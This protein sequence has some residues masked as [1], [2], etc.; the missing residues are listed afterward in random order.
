MFPFIMTASP[1][2]F[3]C[4]IWARERGQLSQRHACPLSCCLPSAVWQLGAHSRRTWWRL[5]ASPQTGLCGEIRATQIKITD[6]ADSINF[7]RLPLKTAGSLWLCVF[8]LHHRLGMRN[9][10]IISPGTWEEC[11]F[12][13]LVIFHA[14]KPFG[15][16][17]T[18][19]PGPL[20]G[21][22]FITPLSFLV[23]T[24]SVPAK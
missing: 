10:S 22:G 23:A 19:L 9:P 7:L 15:G 1:A 18:Q 21:M 17:E 4:L 16:G 3:W 24:V 12:F 2:W 11:F 6:I 13:V 5:M 8:G 14:Q 20:A